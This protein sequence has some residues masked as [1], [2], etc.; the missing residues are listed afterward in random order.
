VPDDY[1]ELLNYYTHGGY[2]V[3][4]CATKYMRAMPLQKLQSLSRPEA[5][6]DL[7]FVGL[8]IF[9]NKLKQSTAGVISE[10]HDANIRSVMCTGDNILTAVSVARECGLIQ[11]GSQCFAPYFVEGELFPAYS[12]GWF[13]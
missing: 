12:E 8:I 9:E 4:A 6:S 3:I 2:R 1:D 10:L 13:F 7:T 5:E 11:D